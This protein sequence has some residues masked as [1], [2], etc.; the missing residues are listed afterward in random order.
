MSKAFTRESD[1]AGVDEAVSTRPPTVSG[2]EELHHAGGCRPAEASASS[3]SSKSGAFWRV[4]PTRKNRIQRG[5]KRIESEIRKVQ[6]AL[7][8]AIVAERPA[9]QRRRPWEPG[10]QVRGDDD[11]EETYQIVGVDE[12]DAGQGRISSGSP[13][14]RVLL[15]RRAGDRVRFQSPAGVQDLTI[16]S[17]RF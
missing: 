6:L 16:I 11:E 5:L 3:I 10:V 17:V 7:D 1:D 12:A 8:S 4:T 9:D 15:S 13:L 14:A 2:R